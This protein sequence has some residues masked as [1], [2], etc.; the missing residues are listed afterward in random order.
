[1]PRYYLR[2]KADY[3]IADHRDDLSAPGL[4]MSFSILF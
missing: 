2:L 4:R 1:V 3:R